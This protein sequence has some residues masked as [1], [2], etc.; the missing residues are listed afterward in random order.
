MTKL[1]LGLRALATASCLAL[2]PQPLPA[3]LCPCPLGRLAVPTLRAN[4]PRL[5]IARAKPRTLPTAITSHHTCAADGTLPR[6]TVRAVQ[7]MSACWG[8]AA[9]T[10]PSTAPPARGC[11][12]RARQCRRYH[13]GCAA[14]RAKR[15]SPG[16]WAKREMPSGTWGGNGPQ[17]AGP[18]AQ[19]GRRRKGF[20]RQ[21]TGGRWG[22]GRGLWAACQPCCFLG[23]R[24][25]G[26]QHTTDG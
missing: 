26:C 9:L 12:R 17:R 22:L 15:G 23:H 4:T 18:G 11:C 13:R 6:P 2:P 5:C 20:S 3:R 7:P 8:A 24:A 19:S 14:P 1:K 16:A 21:G 10:A 25:C